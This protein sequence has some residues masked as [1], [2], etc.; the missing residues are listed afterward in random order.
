MNE[1]ARGIT[2]VN[3]GG[4]FAMSKNDDNK[5]FNEGQTLLLTMALLVGITV[6]LNGC[7]EIFIR[8]L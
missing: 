4:T 2:T 8:I 3:F 6:L 1:Y 5:N 7:A